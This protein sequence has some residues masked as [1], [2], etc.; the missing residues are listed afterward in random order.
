M[1]TYLNKTVQEYFNSIPNAGQKHIVDNAYD[2][3][4]CFPKELGLYVAKHI[5]QH[6]PQFVKYLTSMFSKSSDNREFLII[7]GRIPGNMNLKTIVY[8]IMKEK[9]A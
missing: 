5:K 6:S 3:K 7:G 4:F 1:K 9:G 2:I 8:G